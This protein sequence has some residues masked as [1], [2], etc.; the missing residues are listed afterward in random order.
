M[1]GGAKGSTFVNLTDPYQQYIHYI[2]DINPKKQNQYIGKTAHKIVS[3]DILN[4]LEKGDIFIMNENYYEEI[5]HS[6][7]NPDFNFYVLGENYESLSE[8]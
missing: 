7:G 6:V 3:P 8:A 5:R 1:G 2:I 4:H